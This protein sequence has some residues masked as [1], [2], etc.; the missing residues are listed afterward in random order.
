MNLFSVLCLL[1][2]FVLAPIYASA[3]DRVV[4]KYNGKDCL[5][6]EVT[7]WIKASND[8][9]LPENKKDLDDF[10]PKIQGQIING[11]VREKILLDAAEKSKYN[12][13]PEYRHKLAA[14]MQMT[15]VAL[16]LDEYAKHKISE[17]MLKE[18]YARY[19]KA[20]KEHDD[21]KVSHILFKT[22][23][24]ADKVYKEIQDKKISFDDAVKQYSVDEGSKARNGQIGTMSYGGVPP[25]FMNLQQTAY[26]LKEGEISKPVQT[27]MGWHILKLLSKQKA[28]VPSFDEIKPALAAEA[29]ERRKQE[30][31]A[32][33][34]NA[35]KVEIF[36]DNKK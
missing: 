27:K 34:F 32:Q 3:T 28:K 12:D 19:V 8:G 18:G 20:L 9:K 25:E 36:T 5:K 22:E 33:L 21:L 7:S 4:A 23:A 2:S 15:K 10:S 1:I 31:V 11:Y 14:L 13:N 24:E 26:T 6:S 16:Y 30:H 35:G 29:T 17:S